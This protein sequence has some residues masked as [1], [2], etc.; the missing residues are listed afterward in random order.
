MLTIVCE[1]DTISL[2]STLWV[3][4]LWFRA[5]T[6]SWESLHHL[7]VG[8]KFVGTNFLQKAIIL[9]YWTVFSFSIIFQNWNGTGRSC[10]FSQKTMN[11]LR[12]MVSMETLSS[13]LIRKYSLQILIRIVTADSIMLHNLRARCMT[14]LKSVPDPLV[15]MGPVYES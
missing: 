15:Y 5:I 4:D 1:L 13:P 3:T 12:G 11:H 14:I 2:S 8:L 6:L 10:P 9:N 7:V